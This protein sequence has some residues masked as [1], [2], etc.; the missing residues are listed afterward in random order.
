MRA[1]VIKMYYEPYKGKKKG[2]GRKRRSFGEW[3][4]QGLLKLIAL[5][6]AIGLMVLGLLYALPPG[7]FAVEPEGVNL[8]LTD[9][10][11]LNCVNV[12]LLGVDDLREGAQRSDAVMIASVGYG[13]FKL[14]SVMRD[15]LVEIPDHGRN[16]LNAAY[17][18]GGAEMV[19][20]TLNQNFGLNIMHY[21]Q[22]DYVALARVIDAIGGVEIT[23]TDAERERLNATMLEARRVFQPL[24]YTAREVTR[25]GDNIPLDGL[26]AA[27]Y[28]RIRK[29]DSDYMRTSRQRTLIA[30]I[31]KKIRSNLWN[32]VML[33]RLARTVTESVNTN[34][35]LLQILSLGEKALLAGS[36]EQLRLP[37]EGSFSD[38]G[39]KLDVTSYPANHD[40]FLQFVYG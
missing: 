11:P 24:G 23:I 7:L 14:T 25:Y 35:S 39:A 13:R 27:S 21:A 32:P 33:A 15:T 22:V 31:L 34:M 17:A 1:L 30:A 18:Y 4:L 20:R 8:A 5:I 3:L 16:K 9:G 29:I 12:L 19:M 26:Q 40:A 10:L 37:V 2:K 6:L 36:V 38:D 28:V